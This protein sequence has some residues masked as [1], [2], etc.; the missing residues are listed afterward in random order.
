MK[1][2]QFIRTHTE[3]KA[4]INVENIVLYHGFD[5]D[6]LWHAAQ[7]FLALKDYPPPFWAFPW[8]GGEALA[9][10]IL[11]NPSYVDNKH[12]FDF[13]SG[14]GLVAIAAKKAGAKHVVAYDIDPFSAHVIG[15]NAKLNKIDIEISTAQLL[16]THNILEDHT[17]WDIIL[18]G[19][20]FYDKI[21]THT[22][23]QW[24]QKLKNKGK[25]V[26]I[27]CPE[28]RH[29]P[30]EIL[31]LKAEYTMKTDPLIEGTPIKKAQIWQMKYI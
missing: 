11:E 1:F 21:M 6:Q 16:N 8:A 12:V 9:R 17:P 25:T 23:I 27:G 31:S 5:I 28:R 18:A 3:P 15:L 13:A 10:Y 24:L 22:I 29:T 30:T 4:C 7:K 26:L 19:D 14:S 2:D 20:I